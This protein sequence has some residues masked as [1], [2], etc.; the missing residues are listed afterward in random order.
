[1]I[2]WKEE[3]AT[4]IE[5]IDVQHMW[6]FDFVNTLERELGGQEKSIDVGHILELLNGYIKRHFHDEEG[7]MEK[8]RCPAA[9]SN[10]N[11]HR[12]FVSAFEVFFKKYNQE[13]NSKELAR[14]IHSMAEK[15]IINHICSIDIQL[16]ACVKHNST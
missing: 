13:G 9:I 3:F 15:W 5:K 11:A 6:L 2:Q 8:Y 4:G 7:C 10:K 14:E 16:R 12:Q 1:M